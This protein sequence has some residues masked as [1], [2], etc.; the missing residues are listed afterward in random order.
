M[1]KDLK[2]CQSQSKLKLKLAASSVLPSLALVSLNPP[3]PPHPTVKVKFQSIVTESY[4]IIDCSNNSN[5]LD[6]SKLTHYFQA[7]SKLKLKLAAAS[8]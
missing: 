2:F 1:F 7:Q 6:C 3:P 5:Y 8:S 4:I